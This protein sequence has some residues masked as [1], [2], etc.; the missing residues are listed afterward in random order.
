MVDLVAQRT[1]PRPTAAPGALAWLQLE[2]VRYGTRLPEPE[3]AAAFRAFAAEDARVPPMLDDIAAALGR[4]L[5]AATPAT[6]VVH[7]APPVSAEALR[8]QSLV[9]VGG[10]A[11]AMTRPRLV[12]A[13]SATSGPDDASRRFLEVVGPALVAARRT[14]GTAIAA[15]PL[16][17]VPGDASPRPVRVY[18]IFE[19]GTL[20]SAPWSDSETPPAGPSPVVDR[21]LALLSARQ[22]V[23]WFAPADFF[24]DRPARTTVDL[25]GG[26]LAAASYSGFYLDL[27]GR[28]LVSTVMLPMEVPGAGRALFA[29]DLAFAIDWAAFASSIDAPVAG[30]AVRVADASGAS[31]RTLAQATTEAPHAGLRAAVDELAARSRAADGPSG[32]LRHGILRDEGA[33]AAFQVSDDT[34]I[35]MLFPRASPIFPWAAVA[36]LGGLLAV[37]IG[38]FEVNRRRAE[39]ERARAENAMAAKQNLLNTMQ[40]PLVVVDPNTDEIVSSNLAASAI[41]IRAGTRFAELVSP[42]PAAR[43]HYQQMQV[44]ST[45]PRRAYGVPVRVRD[46]Q[47]QT[48]DRYAVVRSVAV[49]APIDVLEA[50]ERHRLG[51][52]FLLEP[53]A[54]LWLLSAAVQ[55][56]ARGDERRRLAGLLSHGVDTLAR[57]LEHCLS[58]RADDPAMR[59]F[60]AWLADYLERRLTVTAWLLE[61]WDAL[62]PLPSQ[63]VVDADQARATVA[64]LEAVFHLVASDRALRQRLHWENGTLSSPVEGAALI[65][66]AIDWPAA[67]ECPTPVPGGFGLFLGEVLTNAVRHGKPGTIPRLTITADRVRRELV[68]RV[69]NAVVDDA[70]APRGE[71]YGGLSIVRA[72][73]RLFGWEMVHLETMGGRTFVAEWRVP[74]FDRGAAGQAD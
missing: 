1:L 20:L 62:P 41:G 51:V 47:G 43:A 29:L 7:A 54:D 73:A 6:I 39:G 15:R 61:H 25:S 40:V 36:L 32:P 46:D 4:G 74:A 69:E 44:A 18:A 24:F 17:A 3:R 16:P 35:L 50:D 67:F 12:D 8:R 31:W 21:E 63:G 59:G 56:E 68:L 66:A 37:L 30:M 60:T 19:D 57:V 70:P 48:V 5:T 23:P 65:E 34:W 45:Q 33:V 9:D 27:G 22:A 38:G 11:L 42:D 53:E 52:L 64:R 28:G 71:A 72:M 49:T 14:V 26:A 2:L 58:Q 13:A 55:R 10:E